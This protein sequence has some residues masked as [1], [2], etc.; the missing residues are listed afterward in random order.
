[1]KHGGGREC[2]AEGEGCE[3]WMGRGV[4]G[5]GKGVQD[6]GRRMCRI[7]GELCRVEG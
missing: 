1:V 2:W 7:E 3:G 6:G 5:G 4:Q